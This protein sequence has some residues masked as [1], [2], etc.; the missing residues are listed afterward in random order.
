[1]VAGMPKGHPKYGGRAAGTPNKATGEIRDLV[2]QYCPAAV[3]ELARLATK[4][5]SEQARVSA[6]KELFDRGF[7]KA[8]QPIAGSA[9]GDPIQTENRTVIILP[10]NG[11]D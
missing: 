9:E 5:N 4:A 6:I 10:H 2:R 1:M 11:R 3:V 8:I 7:G